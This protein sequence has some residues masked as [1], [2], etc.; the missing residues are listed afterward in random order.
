MQ[1]ARAVHDP[2]QSV[3]QGLRDGR[4]RLHNFFRFLG[5]TIGPIIGAFIAV[6]FGVQAVILSVGVLLV[7]AALILQVSLYDPFEAKA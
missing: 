5:A 2:G 3:H 1:P 6:R 7:I 4:R